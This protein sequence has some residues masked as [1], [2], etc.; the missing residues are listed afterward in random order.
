MKTIEMNIDDV[1]HLM[2]GGTLELEKF[3]LVV[4]PEDLRL[5][6]ERFPSMQSYPHPVP[7]FRPLF[8][9]KA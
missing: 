7:P 9:D 3:E 2:S 6:R 8:G 1:I 5:I 4:R